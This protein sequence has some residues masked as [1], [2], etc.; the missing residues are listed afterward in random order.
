[1]QRTV[2]LGDEAGASELYELQEQIRTLREPPPTAGVDFAAAALRVYPAKSWRSAGRRRR[3]GPGGGALGRTRARCGGVE[4]GA[5]H[6]D[7][8][9]GGDTSIEPFCDIGGRADGEKELTEALKEMGIK[10]MGHRQAIV[11]AVMG[12]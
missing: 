7:V 3:A 10:K 11:G 2:L 1:M 4:A 12:K 9:G 5:V 6:R 8:R